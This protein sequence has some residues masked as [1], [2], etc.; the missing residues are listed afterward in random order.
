ML[1]KALSTFYNKH[2][3]ANYFFLENNME[4]QTC[5]LLLVSSFP[6]EWTIQM[7]CAAEQSHERSFLIQ[8]IKKFKIT[9][10]KKSK[11]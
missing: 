1:R 5:W 6:P 3:K 9:N 8:N 10:G 4:R 2:T 7:L 11:L